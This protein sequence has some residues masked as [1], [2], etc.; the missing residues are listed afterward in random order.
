M[1]Q[2]LLVDTEGY[3]DDM[4]LLSCI[5]YVQICVINVVSENLEQKPWL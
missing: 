3:V 1:S 4:V 2:S 5:R